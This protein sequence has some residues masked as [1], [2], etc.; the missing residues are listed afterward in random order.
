MIF[1]FVSF[2]DTI[3]RIINGTIKRNCKKGKSKDKVDKTFVVEAYH[4]FKVTM[5][6][7]ASV[8][9]DNDIEKMQYTML[10]ENHTIEKGGNEESKERIWSA[11]SH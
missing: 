1:L 7:N 9:T 4:F 5:K 11:K 3:K 2:D 10:R 6:Y 8:N